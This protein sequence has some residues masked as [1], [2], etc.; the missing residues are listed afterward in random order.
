MKLRPGYVFI[1]F[2]MICL[3]TYIPSI[4]AGFVFDFLGW[5]QR[6]NAGHFVDV[7]S[8]FGN[9]HNQQAMHLF[10]YSLYK[11]FWIHGLPWYIVFCGLHAFNTW[12][13]YVWLTKLNVD[14]QLRFSQ[15]L[16]FLVCL[17]FMLH[18]YVI[19]P[20][21]W[22]A[23]VHYLL[24]LAAILGIVLFSRRF[25]L[26]SQSRDLILVILIYVPSLFLLE[27]AYITPLLITIYLI[28]E[29]AANRSASIS[30]RSSLLLCTALWLCL[31]SSFI[32]N[33]LTLGAWVGHY[34][35]ETHLNIDLLSMASTEFKYLAKHLLD[36]RVWS[37]PVKTKFFDVYM[38]SDT[39]VITL[40]AVLV[41]WLLVYVWRFKRQKG[42]FHLAMLGLIGTMLFVLPVSN[43]FF[44]YFQVGM[45]DRF[46]YVPLLFVWM[47]LLPAFGA[48]PKKA[49]LTI[50]CAILL[51]HLYWQQ[52]IL[53]YWE[54]STDVLESLKQDYRWRDKSHV[55]VLN[56]PDNYHGIVMTSAIKA[57]SGIDELIDYQTEAPNTG[58]MY[59]IYQFN[60]TTPND[61]VKVEQTDSLQLKVTFNQW[62]NWWHRADGGVVPYE[63]EYYKA[64]PLDYPYLVTFKQLPANSAIIYQDGMKWK[65][66]TLR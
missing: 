2:T 27:I 41:G 63:N 47:A 38:S 37:H 45:N 56:S 20:V 16:L 25:A 57:D 22:K 43:L 39:V 31:A 52:K 40:L 18:P 48:L 9:A 54:K 62:G 65:E 58:I 17:G 3:V 28:I 1:A 59:D 5:Q 33:K 60:M 35:A 4:G 46:S 29:S 55:F 49:S 30:K 44:Y 64:E 26:K 32:V 13:A 42:R 19:E 15:T 11:L 6:Y 24:S 10:F 36:A 23:C 8:S 12:L 53:G 61:G 21:V 50:L 7:F 51:F 14:W 34:G 66:V